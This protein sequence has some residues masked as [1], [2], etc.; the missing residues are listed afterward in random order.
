MSDIIKKIRKNGWR[1]GSCLFLEEDHELIKQKVLQSGLYVVITQDCDLLHQDFDTE[2]FVELLR[3]EKIDKPDGNYTRGKNPRKIHIPI[4]NPKTEPNHYEG[5][6]RNRFT[7]SREKLSTLMPAKDCCLESKTLESLIKWIVKRY[8]RTAFPD[9]LYK[10]IGEENIDKIK[11]ILKNYVDDVHH[12]LFISLSTYEELNE[13]EPYEMDI[14]LLTEP[15]IEEEV[16]KNLVTDLEKIYK[17]IHTDGSV[18]VRDDYRVVSLDD[19]DV[20][21]YNELG[22]LDFEYL[23]FRDQKV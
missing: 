17:I 8:K 11:T 1:Q 22:S 21:K 12:G 18:N 2:P 20:S 6:I 4:V 15:H 10:R 7:I 16:F 19:I 23:S 9:T 5:I 13:N 14:Y 3:I